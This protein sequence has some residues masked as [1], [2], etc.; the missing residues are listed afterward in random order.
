MD[1]YTK[2]ADDFFKMCN[3]VLQY[4]KQEDVEE[5]K[6]AF[7]VNVAGLQYADNFRIFPYS[8]L[9]D[10]KK[11]KEKGCCGFFDSSVKCVSGNIYLIGC[12]FGH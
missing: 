6:V 7:A 9:N 5:V 2:F 12:N 8:M 10:Y 1:S 4:V 3:N 11:V